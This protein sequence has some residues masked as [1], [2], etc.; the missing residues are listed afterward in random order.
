[1][2]DRGRVLKNVVFNA[3]GYLVN[4][5]ILFFLT[6]YVVDQLGDGVAGGWQLIM[7]LVGH[8]GLL[9]LGIRSAIGFFVAEEWA[10]RSQAGVNRVMSTAVVY[11][12]GIAIV[13]GLVTVGVWWLARVQQSFFLERW[14]ELSAAELEGIPTALLIMGLGFSVNLV[15]AAYNTVLYATQRHDIQNAVGVGQLVV[16]ALL[17]WWVLQAGHGVIGLA[18]VVTLA[19]ALGWLA[20]WLL[21]HRLMPGLR[22]R[23]Y[24][25][26]RKVVRPLFRYGFFNSLVNAGDLVLVNSD[27][28]L[29]GIFVTAQAVVFYNYGAML[30]PQL[31][32]VIQ[33]VTW[34]FTPYATACYATR[35]FAALR[36]LLFAGTRGTVALGVILGMGMILYGKDFLQ[37]WI[38]PRYTSGKVYTSSATVLAVLATATILR[39]TQSCTRQ[40]L[41]GINQVRFLGV[42]SLLEAGANLLISCALVGPF[43]LLGIAIGTLIPVFL[44]QALVQPIYV[45]RILQVSYSRFL[46]T[47]LRAGVPLAL[48]MALASQVVHRWFPIQHWA[49]FFLKVSLA[50]GPAVLVALFVVLTARERDLVARKLRLRR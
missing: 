23:P 14:P 12:G 35:D 24:L 30:V 34:A 11:L 16:R 26:H 28:I 1:M 21:A 29:I 37:L 8:Y 7:S 49:D 43:G 10:R 31:M 27:S 18:L 25:H 47:V 20:Y 36:K 45:A 5:A 32:M 3:S 41:F 4:A 46:S 48:V 19:N 2:A 9:D 38:D 44:T 39:A 17:T 50:T 13:T 6:P 15:M 33:S 22:V 40:I 42:L